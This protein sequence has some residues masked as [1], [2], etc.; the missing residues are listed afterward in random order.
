MI[1]IDGSYLEGGG[2]I[3]RTAV[4]LSAITQKSIHIFNIRKGREKPG[5]RPQ[6]LAGIRAAAKICDAT[7]EGLNLKSMEIIFKPEKIKGGTL[8]I[9]TKTAGSVT[10]ILQALVLIGIFAKTPLN[11]TI[12]GGTAVPFSPTIEYFQH[13]LCFFLEKMGVNVFIETKKHGFYPKGGGEALVKIKPSKIQNINL[14]D[15]GEL[16]K[17]DV[18][19]IAS[20]HL[21]QSRVAERMIDGFKKILSDVNTKFEYVDTFS[22]GCFMRSHAHFES[23][24]LGADALGKRG[25]RAEDVGM[26][27]AR[28]LK[29]TIDTGTPI[30]PW[31]VDQIIPYMALSAD[32]AKAISKIKIP[33]LTK[34]AETNIW[35]V[36]KFLDV[37]FEIQDN[38]IVCSFR[39]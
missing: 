13:V 6:H 33:Q 38:I 22:P 12:R 8:T 36:K 5:L 19:S 32:Q 28:E 17:I 23:G 27:A 31:M 2:Q 15:R 30:D 20:H 39:K 14:I 4:A 3:I 11:L 26:D 18:L 24:K 37:A 34:H 9:D 25:K 35:V 21:R 1:E 16:Q 7:A 10:L 29:S